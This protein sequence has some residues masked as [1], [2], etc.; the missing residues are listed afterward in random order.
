MRCLT[1]QK[2]IVVTRRASSFHLMPATQ[3]LQQVRWR[4]HRRRIPLW[5]SVTGIGFAIGGAYDVRRTTGYLHDLMSGRDDV[6][7]T[8]GFGCFFVIMRQPSEKH[9]R[10]G[11]WFPVVL[12]APTGFILCFLLGT[13]MNHALVQRKFSEELAHYTHA[14]ELAPWFDSWSFYWDTG[15]VLGGVLVIVWS[16]WLLLMRPLVHR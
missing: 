10:D 11:P 1:C 9:R 7:L 6:V 8:H 15:I 2:G 3:L 16:C 5:I 4:E 14:R 13:V 12:L